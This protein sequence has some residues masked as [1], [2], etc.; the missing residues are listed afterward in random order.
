[1][2]VSSACIIVVYLFMYGVRGCHIALHNANVSH[3][4][5]GHT[6]HGTYDELCY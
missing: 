2:H 3:R 5:I 4:L 1:M 6:V